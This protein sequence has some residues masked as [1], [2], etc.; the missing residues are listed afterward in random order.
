M[1]LILVLMFSLMTN[2]Y[3]GT[4]RILFMVNEGFNAEEY[5]RPLNIFK[6]HGFSVK[7]AARDLSEVYPDIRQR[8]TFPSVRPDLD[9][10]HIRPEDFDAIVF[11]G[12]NGAW[13]DFFPNETVH[14][15]LKT[16]MQQG[17]ITALI[18]ASTGLL[19]VANNL[20]GEG[21]VLAAGKNVTG[22]FRVK[23]LLKVMG[24]VNYL[25]GDEG[26]PFVVV[27]GNLITGR[28]PISSE[29]FGN[30]IVEELL[31]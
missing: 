25:P 2:A 3:A 1:K 8:K 16:F 4:P 28:D 18:C 14:K 15:I 22:Y 13:E 23:G 10:T 19:G 9:F 27:D 29:L 26:K 21:K 5:Y 11:A 20:D 30:T 24:K 31:K 7:T 12:G 17:K 6:G